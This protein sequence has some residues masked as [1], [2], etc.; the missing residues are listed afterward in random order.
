MN[1]A[2]YVVDWVAQRCEQESR[3][4]PLL[5]CVTF[6]L[7]CNLIATPPS[8]EYITTLDLIQEEEH[9]FQPS[10]ISLREMSTTTTK[11]ECLAF[12]ANNYMRQG[13]WR[14][15]FKP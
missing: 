6:K 13:S 15:F 1:V 14:S 8:A 2:I 12:Q 11:L 4:S 3:A 5:L 9:R 7:F 10:P